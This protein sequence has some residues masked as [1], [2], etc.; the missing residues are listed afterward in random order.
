MQMNCDVPCVVYQAVCIC[1]NPDCSSQQEVHSQGSVFFF[2]FC[3]TKP[4]HYIGWLIGH[5]GK[6]S[7]L[8]ILREK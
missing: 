8:P 2:L 6:G 5:E 7:I 4:M 1:F 3:R